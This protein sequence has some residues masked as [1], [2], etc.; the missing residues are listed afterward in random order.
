MKR[1]QINKELCNSI[2]KPLHSHK[3]VMELSERMKE[4]ANGSYYRAFDHDTAINIVNSQSESEIAA[5]FTT[6]QSNLEFS[7][8]LYD[9][10]KRK[11]NYEQ[12]E[13]E[14]WERVLRA[15]NDLKSEVGGIRRL[16]AEHGIVHE[17]PPRKSN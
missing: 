11:H 12:G 17:D 13:P 16:L 2:A 15:V 3:Q 4:R 14:I 9:M 5:L 7:K 1:V 6:Q 10:N 8:L